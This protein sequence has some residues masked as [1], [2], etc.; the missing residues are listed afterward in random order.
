MAQTEQKRKLDG[1]LNLMG[2]VDSYRNPNLLG[3][4]QLAFAINTTI[5]GGYANNRPGFNER[6]IVYENTEAQSWVES[7]NIQGV[8]Y[9]QPRKDTP[10]FLFSSGG[11]IFE[12]DVLEDYSVND[13]TP[14]LTQT[15]DTAFVSPAIGSTVSITVDDGRDIPVGYPHRS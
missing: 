2:G 14:T 9:Y 12:L 7:H 8:G 13:I 10:Y 4:N 1:F 3:P 11:R 15:V 5:R 6:P